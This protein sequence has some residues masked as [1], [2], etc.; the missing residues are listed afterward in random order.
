MFVSQMSFGHMTVS[1]LPTG[2]VSL[3]QNYGMSADQLSV[4]QMSVCNMSVTQMSVNQMPVN[5]MS[6][7]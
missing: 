7:H 5:Q 3:S 2:K 4:S 1:H 6:V